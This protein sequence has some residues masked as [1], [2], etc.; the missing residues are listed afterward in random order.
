MPRSRVIVVDDE[1][2]WI[3][4]EELTLDPESPVAPED[5]YIV[6][7]T[8][9]P[10]HYNAQSF[11]TEIVIWGVGLISFGPVT[12]EQTAFMANLGASTDLSLFPGDYAA[13][14]FSEQQLNS[15]QYGI[16]ENF[17]YA[18][19]GA[20]TLFTITPDGLTVLNVFGE[21]QYFG[22]DFGGV[23]G[24]STSSSTPASLFFSDLDVTTG[25]GAPDTMVGIDGPETLIGLGGN[26]HL[27]GNGGGDRLE[28][29]VGN[30]LLEGGEGND[31]LY[32]GSDNDELYGGAGNDR[33]FGDDGNDLLVPGTGLNDADGGAGID[34][35]LLDYGSNE[36]SVYFVPGTFIPT[37]GGGIVSAVNVEAM[38]VYGSNY[39]DVL[40]G[41]AFN[42]ELYGGNGFDLL[43]GGAGNDLL[44]SGANSGAPVAIL[45]IAGA[46]RDTALPIDHF[47][48]LAADPEIFNSTTVPHATLNVDVHTGNSEF[49][50][51]TNRYVAIN[52][53]AGAT[54][55]IDVDNTFFEVDTRVAIYDADGNLVASNDDG[56][57]SIEG[58]DPGSSNSSDS[59]LGFTF[60][61]AGT[62]YVE[63]TS[64]IANSNHTSSFSVNFSL[65]SATVAPNDVLE[66]GVGDDTYIVHSASDAIIEQAGGGVDMVRSDVSYGLASNVE[67]LT[68][69]GTAAINGTGNGLAN[70][71][72]G[73]SAAN[74]INGGGGADSLIGGAG[75]DQFKF[76]DISDSAPGAA[77]LILDFSG[78]KG[79]SALGDKIDLSAIDAISNTV[80]D[81][82]FSLVKKFSG[83]AGQAYVAYDKQAG[84]TSINLDVDGDG[85]ADMIINLAGRIN[86]AAGDFFF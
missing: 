19:L 60:A 66:G 10:I 74:V 48:T 63:V 27:I 14:G 62:Y 23:Q 82:A 42:D 71:I 72:T 43:R 78:R 67:N 83:Q 30:D 56:D 73:N 54:L 38:I 34:Q 21:P 25:T 32:G 22:F 12:A 16:K 76:A 86:L 8:G 79:K 44:D 45:P 36:T 6:V 26:D 2:G 31:R 51:E 55:T 5:D 75:A 59:L 84:V 24:A 17:L 40:I 58:L 57:Y 3:I 7:Q 77:D 52:V 61:S 47:F 29:G 85:N 69:T 15:F 20:T 46:T 50:Q 4:R 68:L 9:F 33:L 64:F 81:D 28:G 49:D 80:A 18:G 41:T 13:F 39:S 70:A 35:L 37:S 53:D 1:E 11:Y 65:T